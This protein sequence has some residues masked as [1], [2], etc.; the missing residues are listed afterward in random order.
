MDFKRKVRVTVQSSADVKMIG[1]AVMVD[2]KFVLSINPDGTF[3][4]NRFANHEVLQTD[5]DGRIIERAY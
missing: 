4:R 1:G 3:T 2:D 5:K